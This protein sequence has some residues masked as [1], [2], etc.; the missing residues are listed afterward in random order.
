MLPRRVI[1]IGG[2]FVFNDACDVPNTQIIYYDFPKAPVLYEVHNLTKARGSDEM[3]SFRGER[4][5][6]I[7]DCEGGSV[8]LYRGIAWDNKGKEVKRFSGGGDHFIDF[9]EAIRS[10]RRQDLN[11]EVLEGHVSTAVAHTGN[12]SYRLGVKA[13]L[14]KMRTQVRD[15]PIFRSMFK[16]MLEHLKGHEI[17]V[18]AKSVTLGPWLQIDRKNECFRDNEQANRLVRGFYREPYVV[19]DLSV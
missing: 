7:V 15:I 18:N 9:I 11:A 12:I 1:S 3:P 19:P 4:V 13:S 10:G 6:V 17:N 8:S 2:R 16:R 5:G 14:K